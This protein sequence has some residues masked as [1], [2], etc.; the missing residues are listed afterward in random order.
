MQKISHKYSEKCILGLSLIKEV[1]RPIW[2]LF[3]HI[4]RK[5]YKLL[6]EKFEYFTLRISLDLVKN[7]LLP[8][9]I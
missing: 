9:V 2:W 7:D 3:I 8:F 1:V 4:K 5:I 6:T